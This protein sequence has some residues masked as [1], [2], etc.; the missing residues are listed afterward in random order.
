MSIRDLIPW[1]RH[2]N[3]APAVSQPEPQN[4]LQSLHQ[5]VNRLFD[6]VL[7]GWNLPAL[8]GRNSWGWPS[9]EVTETDRELRLT[10]ELPGMTEKDVEVSVEDGVLVLSGEKKSESSDRDRGYSERVYG[11]FERVLPLPSDLDEA[12]IEARFKDGVLT[13]VLPRV[14]DRQRGRRIPIQA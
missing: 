2:Q 7:N 13:V 10:A 11:R 6:D 9:V 5:Q 1:G 8:E 4:P 3:R 14:P 12:K